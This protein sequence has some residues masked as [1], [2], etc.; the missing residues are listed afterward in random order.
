MNV[1][2]IDSDKYNYERQYEMFKAVREAT[3]GEDLICLP[4]D[5]RLLQNAS[6]ESLKEIK[7]MVDK[8]ITEKEKYDVCF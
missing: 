6:L 7:D 2:Y 3:Q 4:S 8:A 1:L 5:T